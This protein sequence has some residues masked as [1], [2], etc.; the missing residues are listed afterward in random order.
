[1]AQTTLVY[2]TAT[3]QTIIKLSTCTCK[4]KN[5]YHNRNC[6]SEK[7]ILLY[8]KFLVC[9]MSYKKSFSMFICTVRLCRGFPSTMKF[10]RTNISVLECKKLTCG[11]RMSG[12][13]MLT[14]DT[15]LFSSLLFDLLFSSSHKYIPL[16]GTVQFM[17]A[18]YTDLLCY[19]LNF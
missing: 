11:Q 6:I 17:H 8:F 13:A 2:S 16:C 15:H 9:R 18:F 3:N 10:N 5:E 4:C 19:R 14:C 1:M 12:S 7:V